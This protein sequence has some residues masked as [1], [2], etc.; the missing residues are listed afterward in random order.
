MRRELEV[1]RRHKGQEQGEKIA[2]ANDEKPDWK[3]TCEYCHT[4]LRGTVDQLMAHTC[5]EFEASRAA[6]S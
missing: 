6:S 5:K 3:G 2:A 4:E 1:I